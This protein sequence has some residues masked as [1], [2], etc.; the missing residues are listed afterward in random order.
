MMIKTC[1]LD[2][3]CKNR[4]RNVNKLQFQVFV[5]TVKV[6]KVCKEATKNEENP[7]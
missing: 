5:I 1:M 3:T 4:K 7:H 6:G 2:I